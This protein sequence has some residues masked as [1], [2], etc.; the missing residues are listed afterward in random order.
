MQLSLESGLPAR[1]QS[2]ITKWISAYFLIWL[3]AFLFEQSFFFN[4]LRILLPTF[5]TVGVFLWFSLRLRYQIQD[6]IFGEIG[7]TYLGFAVAY[8]VFP[9]YG[10]LAQDTLRSWVGIP[11]LE[12]FLPDS[13][14]LAVQL[15]RQVLFIFAVA[16]GYLLFRGNRTPKSSAFDNL[17]GAEK[18]II[19]LLFGGTVLSVVVLWALSA[20]VV[21]YVDNYTR[22]D[23]LSWVGLRIV[24]ICTFVKTGGT[25]VLLPILF[26]NYKRYRMY[27]WSFVL[28]RTVQE[29][30]G[31]LGA[32]IDAF[33]IVSA[34][35]VSYHYCVKQITV[36]KALVVTLALVLTFAAIA[37]VRLGA[38]DSS[39][40]SA[41]ANFDF[42]E[43]GAVFIP[44]FHLYAERAM[45]TLPLVPWQLFFDDFIS[46]VPLAND[47]T[48]QPMYWWADNY[49]PDAVVPPI[50]LGPIALSALWGGE[51]TLFVE[52]FING[53]LFAFLMRWFAKKSG[54]W[55]VMAV[56]VFC[57]STCIMCLKYS[58]FFHL[59]P[60]IRTILPSILII[61][62]LAKGI[63]GGAKL[64]RVAS[65][66]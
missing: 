55:R 52:G 49:A 5:A 60:L 65:P 17:G 51:F 61:S 53:L 23:H 27:I 40:Q 48:W 33:M 39:E 9:A 37:T 21:E 43:L 38:F 3:F 11:I 25:F 10:F 32:R 2:S 1:S 16:A 35:A 24:A 6:N 42:G 36:K 8:T 46:I 54:S 13:S 56:Y 64:A 34:A 66:A 59:A 50:T 30:L 45:G 26:R 14:Q 4:N 20:P 22:Y 58:I 7:F 28:L 15:W 62:V 41:G 31:S 47:K 18:S 44:G 19:F 63:Q 29:I 12:T 57:Y